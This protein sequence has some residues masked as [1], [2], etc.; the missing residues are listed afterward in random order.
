MFIHIARG[1]LIQPP[2]T[3]FGRRRAIISSACQEPRP[4]KSSLF[5]ESCWCYCWFWRFLVANLL[6]KSAAWVPGCS[7]LL[8]TI[9]S[10]RG[11]R[12]RPASSWF[13]SIFLVRIA[14]NRP[15][16]ST[17]IR[18]KT[19]RFVGV[20]VG[21]GSAR[22]GWDQHDADSHP[23]CFRQAIGEAL[24]PRGF[25]RPVLDRPALR[26]EAVAAQLSLPG[27]AEDPSYRT[28]A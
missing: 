14:G 20:F 5:H 15:G 27:P 12:G 2:A 16:R 25:A 8:G 3:A 23:D 1:R 22:Q 4:L 17:G 28:L 9:C 6:E 21:A 13:F 10:P 18:R 11:V 19:N 7:P 26:L 24:Q